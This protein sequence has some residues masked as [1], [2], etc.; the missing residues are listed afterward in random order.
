MAT[1]SSGVNLSSTF[2]LRNYYKN[3]PSACKKSSRKD[4][5]NSKL[6]NEDSRALH[7]AVKALG[8]FEYTEDEVETKLLGSIQALA[9]TYNN[10]L[11]SSGTKDNASMKRYASQLKKLS[12]KYS[13]ELDDIGITI[14]KDGS[15]K[16]NETLLKKADPSSIKKVFGK[17]SSYA[18]QLQ[19]ISKRMTNTSTE[20]IYAEMTGSGQN[21]NLSL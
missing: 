12:S 14:N 13:E 2:Y 19:S 9:N 7:R 15:L 20:A 3:D 17:D 11:E 18:K 8:K 21:V 4:F 16:V 6:S 1:I 5:S 10:A